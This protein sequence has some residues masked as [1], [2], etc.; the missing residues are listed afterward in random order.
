MSKTKA[1]LLSSILITLI[2]CA[3][4]I[5]WENEE[6]QK[7][8]LELS[9]TE[10]STLVCFG[11]S[12]TYGHGSDPATESW[13]ARLQERITIPVINS[14]IDDDTTEDGV[15]RFKTDVLDH[16]PAIIIFDFGGNDIYNSKKIVS[17]NEIEDNFR[18]MFDQIDFTTTQVY[19]MRF[20]N[21]EMKFF[22]LFGAFDRIIK[23]LE[24][25][26]PIIVIWDA[27]TG[28]WGHSDCK[29]DKTHCNAKGYE[30]MAEN[31]YKVIEPCL[32][33]NNI[34]SIKHNS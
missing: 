11:D 8:P 33:K 24:Q 19:F 13:P 30:I 5:E 16:N 31:I 26:Y 32:R 4:S 17:F 27:W 15:R 1:F 22:D 29:Y 10:T 20:Y 6:L 23:N 9:I 18:T 2:S 34:I 3:S 12:L 7:E 21:D 28:A 25:D 14:G